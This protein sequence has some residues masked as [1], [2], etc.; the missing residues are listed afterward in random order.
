ML[1]KYFDI[2]V[3]LKL[4]NVEIDE[5]DWYIVMVCFVVMKFLVVGILLLG[6]LL[7]FELL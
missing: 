2:S 6:I 5:L 1:K 3:I 4:G 7:K